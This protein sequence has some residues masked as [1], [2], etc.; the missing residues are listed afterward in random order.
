M[1]TSLPISTTMPIS[2]ALSRKYWLLLLTLLLKLA[3]VYGQFN[4]DNDRGFF[5]VF[6]VAKVKSANEVIYDLNGPFTNTPYS[7]FDGESFGDFRTDESL[8][9]RGGE[10][11]TYKNSG[12][13]ITG[14]D[15][16]YYV[17]RDGTPGNVPIENFTRIQLRFGADLGGLPNP[18]NPGKP[19]NPGDQRW[20]NAFNLVNNVNIIRGLT[21]G[22]YIIEVFV[23]AN[24]Q[25]C[26]SGG[27]GTMYYSNNSRNFQRTFT[28]SQGPLPVALTSFEAKRQEANVLLNWET[29]SEVDSRGYEIQVSTDSRTFRSL[30]FVPSQSEGSI[31]GRRRYTYTDIE[32][33]KA[34]VRYYRLR[35][36]DLD[37][38]ETF[39][40]PQVVSFGK[41]GALA[42]LI[43]APNPFSSEITL[44]L[45]AQDGT[46]SGTVVVTDMLGRTVFNQPLLLSA[47]TS[48]VQLPELASLPKGLYHLRL[49]LSGE[50]QALKLLKE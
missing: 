30:S 16:Y 3:P 35:Q 46:R 39:Y 49:S 19:Y 47:G 42:A 36:I 45:P 24:V 50:Q 9:I 20:G 4:T 10:T 40:G 29:A 18:N 23:T 44:T 34:G 43:A 17:H 21:P 1:K 32:P 6:V 25:G 27:T 14:A 38:K 13:D 31:V 22:S 12:C 5:D 15:L 11:K 33:N 2:L 48:Q 28:V 26:E 37:N 41:A 7:D 8:M